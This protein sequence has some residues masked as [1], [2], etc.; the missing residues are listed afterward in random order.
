M[1]GGGRLWDAGGETRIIFFAQTF[2][3]REPGDRRRD[4][5]EG[6]YYYYHRPARPG[7][8]GGGYRKVFRFFDGVWRKVALR[9]NRP[10]RCIR[11]AI[12]RLEMSLTE[13]L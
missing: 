4:Y 7:G 12:R 5:C 10:N 1:A 3:P 9:S 11:P 2:A 6:Y 13:S 8:M